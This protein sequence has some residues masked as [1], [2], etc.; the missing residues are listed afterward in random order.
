MLGGE[1]GKKTA[2]KNIILIILDTRLI[3]KSHLNY[4]ERG[5]KIEKKVKITKKIG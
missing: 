1:E 5:S 4:E 3:W 2:Q